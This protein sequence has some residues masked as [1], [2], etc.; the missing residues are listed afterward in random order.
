VI[1]SISRH[2]IQKKSPIQKDKGSIFY[3]WLVYFE[4][5][6]NST[7]LVLEAVVLEVTTTERL[8]NIPGKKPVIVIGLDRL[9]D[10]ILFVKAVEL[11]EILISLV[12]IVTPLAGIAANLTSNLCEVPMTA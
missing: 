2:K 5:I 10:E 11:S 12:S 6:L 3:K 1:Q 9:V 7:V 4:A 8:Y